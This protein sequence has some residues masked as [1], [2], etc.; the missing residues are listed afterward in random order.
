MGSGELL[1]ILDDLVYR[2]I[3]SFD[4]MELFTIHV[5]H[6]NISV[7]FIIAKSVSTRQVQSSHFFKL[8]ISRSFQKSKR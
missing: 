1:L 8:S 2:V 5:H 4:Y 7:I 6:M 3:Q